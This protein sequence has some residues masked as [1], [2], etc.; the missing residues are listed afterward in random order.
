MGGF[1]GKSGSDQSR[2]F[3]LLPSVDMQRSTFD[4]SHSVKTGLYSGWLTPI[5]VDEVLPGDT[6][7]LSMTNFG[8]LATP[9]HPV[10]ENLSIDYFF[11]AV[12]NRL[13]WSNWEKF[14]GAQDNPGDSIDFEIP[15]VVSNGSTGHPEDEMADMFGIPTKV[16]GLSHSSLPFRAYN[17]IWNEWFRSEDLQNSIVVDTDNG[18]DDITDYV[19]KERGKRHD[20]FTSA[21]PWPQKGTS[22]SLPLGTSAPVVGTTAG[23]PKFDSGS[24]T[25]EDFYTTAGDAVY[26]SGSPGAGSVTWG[27]TTGLETDLSSAT[28]ASINELRQAFAV[29]K[30]LERDAR[31]GTRYT[32]ILRSHFGVTSPDQRLQ[33][34]EFLGG[35]SSRVNINP[36]AQQSS[37]DGT[38]PQGHL[39]A[40]GTTST[41]GVGF[42]K[43]FTEHCI[44][45]GLA[46]SRAD[47]TY[48]E[49]L[50]RMW[51]RSTRY[52]FYLPAF[53]HLGE[54]EIK[55]K[56]IFAQGTDDLVADEAAFGYQERWA[57]YRYRQS[58]VCTRFRS[59]DTASLDTYHLAQEFA[60]TLPV[61]DSSFIIESP[62]MQRIKAVSQELDYLLDCYFQ[63]SHA[64][65]MPTYSVPGQI[66]RF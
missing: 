1:T 48:Q 30:V 50:A 32:E 42:V 43:S 60:P 52:D 33:R 37:T 66:D 8:R 38:S 45:I 2:S 6:V 34:P 7:N 24:A 16:P 64:R 10:M 9:I 55:N 49:G 4:R 12:P 65:P 3:S 35:G 5:F 56:E 18:P 13:L 62:P 31:G 23:I 36:V 61:L 51:S 27:A 25:D 53:A 15:Q 21:L 63:I 11:F 29:Q 19:L 57:E 20:Y 44:L 59:N 47:L 54:Q 17:L 46:C 14:M 26:M 41:Q 58:Y 28:A 39:A 40:F 22:V